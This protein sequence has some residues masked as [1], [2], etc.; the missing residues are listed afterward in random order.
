MVTR[1]S[2]MLACA[3]RGFSVCLQPGDQL[4][5][6]LFW[7]HD[8]CCTSDFHPCLLTVTSCTCAQIAAQEGLTLVCLNELAGRVELCAGSD[9]SKKECSKSARAFSTYE[10]TAFC[11]LSVVVC[12]F[13]SL[14]C[15]EITAALW[16]TA[17]LLCQLQWRSSHRN[18][19]M[20]LK[21][22]MSQCARMICRKWFLAATGICL[23]DGSRNRKP[24]A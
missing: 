3:L 23:S 12:A 24:K 6:L 2:F 8:A 5:M 17:D 1:T 16:P 15:P 9:M 22:A 19:G 18:Y 11:A 4:D 21:A 20:L 13:G 7:H 14:R 10:W